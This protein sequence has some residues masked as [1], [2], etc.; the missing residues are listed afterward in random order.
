[1]RPRRLLGAKSVSK[2]VIIAVAHAFAIALLAWAGLALN[3]AISRKYAGV[4]TVFS[5][6]AGLYTTVL[7]ILYQRSYAFHLL[8]NRV[9][10]KLARTHTYWQPHF[11]LALGERSHENQ[12]L[13]DELWDLLRTGEYGRP[14]KREQTPTTLAVAL[15]DL[16]VLKFRVYDGSLDMGFEQKLLV[17]SHLY[18][19][20]RRRLARLAEGI[21]RAVRPARTEYAIQVSFGDGVRNPYYGFFVN[22]VPASLLQDFQVAFRLAPQSDCHIQAGTDHVSVEAPTLSDTFEA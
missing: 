21:T 16:L 1:M 6:A 7:N 13:M 12:S 3:D 15:D 19:D 10:L 14:V 8:V 22:R 5:L 11:H 18:D 20:Y 2:A 9:R 4:V 17:P